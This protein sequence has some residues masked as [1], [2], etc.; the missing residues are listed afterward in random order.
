M[1]LWEPLQVAIFQHLTQHPAFVASGATAYYV[2]DVPPNAKYPY[3]VSPGD[4]MSQPWYT[5]G[6]SRGEELIWSFHVWCD[7]NQGGVLKAKEVGDAVMEAMDDALVV[8]PGWKTLM[9]RRI[10]STLP[11]RQ[12]GDP[13]LFQQV[14]RYRVMLEKVL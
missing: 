2:I 3:V 6:D 7:K 10:F 8:V 4:S 13:N 5:M 1:S 12:D 14:I 9:F 11:M